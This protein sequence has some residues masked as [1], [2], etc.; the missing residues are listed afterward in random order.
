M[1]LPNDI[2]WLN[3]NECVEMVKKKKK[4]KKKKIKKLKKRLMKKMEKKH[5]AVAK[6]KISFTGGSGA[7]G[8]TKWAIDMGMMP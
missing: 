2:I 6:W 1:N 8:L 3:D 7:F 4:K 5:T